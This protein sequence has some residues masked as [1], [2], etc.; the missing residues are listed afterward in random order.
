MRVLDTDQVRQTQ[1]EGKQGWFFYLRSSALYHANAAAEI[2]VLG[3]F[4]ML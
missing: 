2:R 4:D 1:Q 3:E